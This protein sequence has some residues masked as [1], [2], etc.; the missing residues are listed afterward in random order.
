M[1]AEYRMLRFSAEMHPLALLHDVLP[2]GTVGSDRLAHLRQGSTV[3][4]AG[5]VT[6]R[7]RPGTAKGYVFVLMEDE[8]G[9]INVIVKPD[10]YQRDRSAVRMES[11]IA[12]RGRL[13][14]DGATI[15]VIA[16][17]VEALRVEHPLAGGTAECHASL[18]EPLAS[19]PEP[20]EYRAE[21]DGTKP[22]GTSASSFRYLTA[23][24]QSPPGVKNFG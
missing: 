9:P 24:R 13:Q 5:L 23:L 8:H 11:F 16:Y 15:N 12:V 19:L 22:G 6:T 3:R 20:L 21:R 1:I 7:Q 17:D 14:K 2:A 10:I 4:V 18:P